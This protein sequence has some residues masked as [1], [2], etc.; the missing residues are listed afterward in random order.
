MCT[1][2]GEENR[3]QSRCIFSGFPNVALDL[4]VRGGCTS[5]RNVWLATQPNWLILNDI[6]FWVGCICSPYETSNLIFIARNEEEILNFL[7][8]CHFSA[9][10]F[11]KDKRPNTKIAKFGIKSASKNPF[12][13]RSRPKLA[14]PNPSSLLTAC[15]LY[16]HK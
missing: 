12:K 14:M 3:V 10:Q 8:F 15:A 11:S 13:N 6:D 7:R 2:Q 1:T 9:P 4:P 16:V 5:V